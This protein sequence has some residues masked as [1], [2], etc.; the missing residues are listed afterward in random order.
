MM[1]AASAHTPVSMENDQRD[2][3]DPNGD[4]GKM[5]HAVVLFRVNRYVTLRMNR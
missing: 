2:W 5:M 4:G 3:T 1:I